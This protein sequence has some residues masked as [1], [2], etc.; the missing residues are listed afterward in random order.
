MEVH[1]TTQ[2]IYYEDMNSMSL[3]MSSSKIKIAKYLKKLE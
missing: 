2:W 1:N 3:Y